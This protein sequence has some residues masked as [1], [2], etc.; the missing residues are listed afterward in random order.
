MADDKTIEMTI[1]DG[2][3]HSNREPER[4]TKDERSGSYDNRQLDVSDCYFVHVDPAPFNY[5]FQ[6]TINRDIFP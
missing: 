5:D 1:H 6:P 3:D 4:A 2:S